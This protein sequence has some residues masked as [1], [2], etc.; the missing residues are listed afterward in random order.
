MVVQG[1]GHVVVAGT[2]GSDFLLQRF[3]LN[4]NV[5]STF[6]SGGTALTSFGG[7]SDTAYSLALAASGQIVAAGQSGG[8]LRLC[9]L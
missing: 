5:D 3:D 8:E 9:P 6:G 7:T 2:N 4:G 1:G